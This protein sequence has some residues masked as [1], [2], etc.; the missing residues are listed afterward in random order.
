[1]NLALIAN[2]KS[3][4]GPDPDELAERLRALGAEVRQWAVE[5]V[6]RAE[7]R[8]LVAAGGDGTVGCCA[9]RAAQIGAE[10]AVVPVGTAN[11]FARAHGLPMDLE[12]ALEL[13]ATGTR[14]TQPELGILE[15][16]PEFV[17]VVNAGLAP[18]AARAATPLKPRLGPLAYAVGALKAAVTTSPLECRAE[19]DG[20][21]FF[22][23]R[24]W[25][26]IVSCTG[27]FGGGS[28]VGAADPL[29]GELDVTI[30]PAGPRVALARR[31]YGLR[32]GNIA[33]Q[34][35]V[36]HGRGGRVELRLPPGAEVN[37]DGELLRRSR[38]SMRAERAAY[39]LVVPA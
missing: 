21:E 10:L 11:D 39:A 29:D 22:K 36:Q 28:E 33:E 32:K 35:A 18:A 6:A 16:G 4:G 1:M 3:G 20:E 7:G 26:V 30:L 24:A 38:L 23:G 9:A 34:G 2:P 19:I 8:R 5:D 12:E 31:A 37:V 15:D 14:T 27:A 13:A 17:N 25:Q